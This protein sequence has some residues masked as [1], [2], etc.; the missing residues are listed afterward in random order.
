M[1]IP[2]SL[3]SA[4]DRKLKVLVIPSW[5]PTISKPLLGTFMEEQTLLMEQSCEVRVLVGA[6]EHI[7]RRKFLR[8]AGGY[9]QPLHFKL[10]PDA[11][12][13]PSQGIH[14]IYPVMHGIRENKN[15][16]WR[17]DAFN[18]AYDEL[19]N[20]GWRPDI[21]HAHCTIMGGI[22]A[23]TLS[24]RLK[25]PYVIT[26]N[27]LFLLFHES[28][29]IQK[30][31]LKAVKEVNAFLAVSTDKLRQVLLH[32]VDCNSYIVG[33]MV[34]DTTF[35]LPSSKTVKPCFSL[36][37]VAGASFQKDLITLFKAIKAVVDQGHVNI[38]LRLVGLGT[39]GGEGNAFRQAIIDIGISD[40]VKI[41]DSVPRDQMIDLY[42]EADALI[43]S[44]ISEG[45]S[46]SILEAMACGLPVISTIHGG[47]ED[48]ITPENGILTKIR[49]Y[50][51]LADAVIDVKTGVKKYD[52]KRIREIVVNNYGKRVF[53]DRILGIYK[54]VIASSN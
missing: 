31:A 35:Y 42:H 41:E 6:V 4:S 40:Y 22:A 1:H 30:Q 37:T 38:M 46:I 33:N 16:E 45:L 51:A 10:A 5:Y 12:K 8:A 11:I 50:Q 7:G 27:L 39:Y 47:S 44:S 21:I 20:D 19:T 26:E 2:N 49:D 14:F 28:H 52:P 9:L 36:L 34:D 13:P 17:E 43:M 32:H 24:R 15:T 18:R 48:V 25:V 29:E 53:H 3:I 54:E 23:H